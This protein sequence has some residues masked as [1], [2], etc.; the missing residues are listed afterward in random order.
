VLRF[1]PTPLPL[2]DHSRRLLSPAVVRDCRR[3]YPSVTW[4]DLLSISYAIVFRRP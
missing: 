4:A 2:V 1:L 3:T